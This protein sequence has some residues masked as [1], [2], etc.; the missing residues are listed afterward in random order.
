ML[1]PSLVLAVPVYPLASGV[2]L[3]FQRHNFL[4]APA[5]TFTGLSQDL[6]L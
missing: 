6:D 2:W 1:L 5:P 4:Y 3:S